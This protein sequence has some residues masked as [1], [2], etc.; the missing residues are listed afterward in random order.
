M[1]TFNRIIFF[2]SW[3]VKGF[4]RWMRRLQI[5]FFVPTERHLLCA[6]RFS[7]ICSLTIGSTLEHFLLFLLLKMKQ[8][9]VK[10]GKVF[11]QSLVDNKMTP[12]DTKLTTHAFYVIV[13]HPFGRFIN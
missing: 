8:T 10:K 1:L 12:A 11:C 7:N 5:I 2:R 13:A 6:N 3:N 4:L 9:F